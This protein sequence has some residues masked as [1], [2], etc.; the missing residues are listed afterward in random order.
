M[1]LN[2]LCHF[3]IVKKP[4][5]VCWCPCDCIQTWLNSTRALIYF[6]TTTQMK[7]FS[8]KLLK[9]KIF[10]IFPPNSH[11]MNLRWQ[12]TLH[13]LW[14]NI[15]NRQNVSLQLC[16]LTFYF[17]C[18][19]SKLWQ[20]KFEWKWGKKE[21]WRICLE[22]GIIHQHQDFFAASKL[23]CSAPNQP[24]ASVVSDSYKM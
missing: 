12:G 21:Q 5:L 13:L 15:I 4:D 11:S 14:R 24:K 22:M 6:F 2:A 23:S 9:G 17:C 1:H 10:H 16:F 19:K 20:T 8:C 18:K 3:V 7:L